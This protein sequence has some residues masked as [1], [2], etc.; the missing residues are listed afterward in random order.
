M[1]AHNDD[2][3]NKCCHF[4]EVPDAPTNFTTGGFGSR[5][6]S[7]EWMLGFGG[8]SDLLSLLVRVTRQR[9]VELRVLE[10]AVTSQ[11]INRYIVTTCDV[12]PF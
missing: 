11:D 8:N 2:S 5:W 1:S 4:T 7:L 12:S 9:M 10:I 3:I 6:V